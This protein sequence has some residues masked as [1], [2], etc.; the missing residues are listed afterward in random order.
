VSGTPLLVTKGSVKGLEIDTNTAGETSIKAGR[1]EVGGIDFNSPLV[2]FQ[3]ESA[4]LP[5]GFVV[6]RDPA[7]PIE[8]DQLE[9]TKATFD[10]KDIPALRAG[11]GGSKDES[12]SL[13]NLKF[14]DTIDGTVT[15]KIHFE[16]SYGKKF[17]RSRKA[18]HKID[19]RI[20]KGVVDLYKLEAGLSGLE[21]ATVD[22]EL[23]N[24]KLALNVG[25]LFWTKDVITWDL[26]AEDKK[27]IEYRASG[28][29][30]PIPKLEKIYVSTFAA[31]KFAE[32]DPADVADE[33]RRQELKAK[34]AKDGLNPKEEDELADLLL[35]ELR[36]DVLDIN[37]IVADLNMKGPS[38]ID[39]GTRGKILLGDA[40]KDGVNNLHLTG[41]LSKAGTSRGLDLSIGSINASLENF[42]VDDMVL[43][44]KGGIEVTSVHD[45]HIDFDQLS[46][47]SAHGVV[48]KAVAKGIR[49]TLPKKK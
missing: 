14:L 13:Q 9:I 45:V 21:D 26:T 41:A 22:F 40:T 23:R 1:I 19:L 34:K 39:L 6:P 8:V 30:P 44:T 18:D 2:R 17:L 42:K 11:G 15:A 31:P 3:V 38:T 10:I 25:A 33:A 35:K 4:L 37:E 20:T 16:G 24:G 43:N 12:G 29:A 5:K 47:K 27:L 48:D 28:K 46:P 49:I 32:S 36:V 7:Q